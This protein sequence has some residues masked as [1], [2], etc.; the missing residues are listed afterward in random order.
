M[1]FV[2]D[3]NVDPRI[4]ARLRQDG[5]EV[6][7]VYE[8]NRGLKNAEVLALANQRQAVL[9]T[10]DKDFGEMLQREG[11]KAVGVLLVRLPDKTVSLD[12]KVEMVAHT[13]EEYGHRLQGSLT[14]IK[15]EG[16]RSRPIKQ[17]MESGD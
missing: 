4:I 17:Q 16:V 15:P 6:Y 14:I 7:S 3:E 13:V 10:E 5:H 1:R 8:S 11:R 9:V 12:Q 2:A